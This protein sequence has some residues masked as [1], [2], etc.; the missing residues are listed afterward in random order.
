MGIR[1]KLRAAITAWKTP[2]NVLQAE[3]KSKKKG[4]RDKSKQEEF[5]VDHGILYAFFRSDS[6]INACVHVTVDNICSDGWEVNE[7]VEDDQEAERQREELEK[8]FEDNNWMEQLRNI[9][10]NIV[11]FDDFFQEILPDQ[12]GK[13][14]RTYPLNTEEMRIKR[15]EEKNI[16][17]GYEQWLDGKPVETFD[18][19]EVIHYRL[20]V[21]GDR[22]YGMSIIEPV[23]YSAAVKKFAEK[24]TAKYFE[25]HKP[26]GAWIFPSEMSEDDY[27]ANVDLIIESKTNSNKDIFL[28][29]AGID[30]KSFTAN[31]DMQFQKLI[32]EL[33]SEIVTAMLVPPIMLG[34]PEGSNRSNSEVQ[35]AAFDRRI[36]AIQTAIEYKINMVLIR[37]RFGFDKVE[38]K[39]VRPSKKDELREAQI[40]KEIMNFGSLNEAREYFGLAQKEDDPGADNVPATSGEAGAPDFGDLLSKNH[41]DDDHNHG[42]YTSDLKHPGVYTP[43]KNILSFYKKSIRPEEGEKAPD[44][45]PVKESDERKAASLMINWIKDVRRKVREEIRA[46]PNI[47]KTLT[48]PSGLVKKIMAALAVDQLRQALS[49]QNKAVYTKGV[50]S[51]GQELG[52]TFSVDSD[53]LEFLDNYTFD[54]VKNLSQDMEGKLNQTLRRAAID[55][56]GITQI[57]QEISDN[58]NIEINRAETIARTE[59][60]RMGNYGRLNAYRDAGIEK[61]EWLAVIDD[62]TSQICRNLNGQVQKVGELFKTTVNGKDVRVMSAPA[63]PNCRSTIVAVQEDLD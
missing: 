49:E 50:E 1:D 36:N 22:D 16:P 4:K 39:F 41:K 23:L 19:D 28:K 35:M 48:D 63:H 14:I 53:S 45:N 40:A 46:D 12:T 59:M 11:V 21:F 61:V 44:E 31:E 7:L 52:R 2:S 6:L 25:N 18:L 57:Q 60:Q 13:P 42:G 5:A 3:K 20:N 47:A 29:G 34:I 43:G 38:F 15:D 10:A 26:R 33:R 56:K 51:V 37:E 9:A 62:R 8:F 58:L 24:F 54:L 32:S 55:G 30:F 17:I 27:D